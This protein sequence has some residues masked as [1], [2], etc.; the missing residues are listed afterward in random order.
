M[1]V[2]LYSKFRVLLFTLTLGLAGVWLW[3]GLRIGSEYVHVDLPEVRSD[4]VIQVFGI[5]RRW[6]PRSG[7][8][9]PSGPNVGLE[10]V[11][12]SSKI[13]T[14][15]LYNALHEP[16]FLSRLQKK[17]RATPGSF[18][19]FIECQSTRRAIPI[20]IKQTPYVHRSIQRLSPYSSIFLTIEKPQFEGTCIL[21]VPYD[22]SEADA[23]AVFGTGP[24]AP[25]DWIR[26]GKRV[27]NYSGMYFISDE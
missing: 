16:I 8:S 21:L 6:F 22:K 25:K 1:P 5:E 23:Y 18:P 12:E 17:D 24:F 11:G 2:R 3:N 14:F 13:L 4:S 7:G 10:L 15:R 26:F 20:P 19:Y 27:T 9:G